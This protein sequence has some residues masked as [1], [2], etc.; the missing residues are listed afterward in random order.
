MCTDLLWL[1]HVSRHD[2]KVVCGAANKPSRW[3]HL[4][5]F[6][7]SLSHRIDTAGHIPKEV[8]SI[9]RTMVRARTFDIE[10]FER[11]I[12]RPVRPLAIFGPA[13]IYLPVRTCT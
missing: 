5:V 6:F 4:D 2:F 10:D 8:V 3:D 1:S 12:V 13:P 7:L 9:N 11:I